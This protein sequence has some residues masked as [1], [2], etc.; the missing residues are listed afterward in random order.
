MRTTWPRPPYCSWTRYDSPEII[1]VGAG[2]DITIRD[3]AALIQRVVGYR[4]EILFDPAKPDGTPQE[5]VGQQPHPGAGL[6]APHLPG[7]GHSCNLR[8]VYGGPFRALRALNGSHLGRIFVIAVALIVYGSLYPFAFH[9]RV[10]T[11]GPLWTVLHAWPGDLDRSLL[12]DAILNVL[13]YIPIGMFGSLWLGKSKPRLVSGGCVVFLAFLLS[14][15]IETA[16]LFDATRTSSALDVTTN[17]AGATLGV[18]LAF[19]YGE[20]LVRIWARPELRAAFR[21][22]AALLLLCCWIGAETFPLIPRLSRFQAEVKLAALWHTPSAYPLEAL[23]ALIDWLAVARLIELATGASGKRST[24]PRV[25]APPAGPPLHRRQEPGLA[26][27]A[28]RRLRLGNLA[29]FGCAGVRGARCCW[30]GPPPPCS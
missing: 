17:V 2:D 18:W 7:R 11:E 10:L 29:C 4:G 8:V 12:G 24:L 1:N 26:G 5:T 15:S 20:T 21:P 19:L 23:G 27:T 30:L 28:G 3:L 9:P 22:S 16:Q 25:S 13:I 14:L 6:A